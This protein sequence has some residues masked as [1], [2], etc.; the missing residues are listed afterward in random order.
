M[1]D[2]RLHSL[3]AGLTSVWGGAGRGG[4]GRVHG[5]ELRVHLTEYILIYTLP[6]KLSYPILSHPIPSYP[7][8]YTCIWPSWYIYSC[9]IYIAI[10]TYAP[11]CWLEGK[12]VSQLSVL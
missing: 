1:T 2:S 4:A 5:Y 3:G 10:T 6:S 7:T 12:R 8:L 9:S 11:R